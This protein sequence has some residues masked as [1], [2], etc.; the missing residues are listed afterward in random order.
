MLEFS[1]V[2]EW[3]DDFS[4]INSVVRSLSIIVKRKYDFSVNFNEMNISIFSL[5]IL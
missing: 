1:R 2:N 5:K 4:S 3:E